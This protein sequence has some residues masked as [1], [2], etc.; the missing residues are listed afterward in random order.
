M[1]WHHVR[2]R[3]QTVLGTEAKYRSKKDGGVLPYFRCK[4]VWHEDGVSSN[5]P[6]DQLVFSPWLAVPGVDAPQTSVRR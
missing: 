6:T 2:A 4:M 5:Y 3:S 1:R